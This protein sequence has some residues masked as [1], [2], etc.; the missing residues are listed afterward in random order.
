[1]EVFGGPIAFYSGLWCSKV[2]NSGLKWSGSPMV[3]SG[4]P[5]VV[6]GGPLKVLWWSPV[7]L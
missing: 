3:V 2:F 5:L 4:G 6:S 1:M 7:V